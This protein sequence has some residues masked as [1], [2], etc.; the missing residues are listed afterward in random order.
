MREQALQEAKL[1]L[2]Q[3]KFAVLST[4]SVKLAGYPMGS[5]VQ[6]FIDQQGDI[7]VFISE[8]AEHTKNLRANNKLAL[9]VIDLANENASQTARTTCIGEAQILPESQQE[10]YKAQFIHHFPDAQKYCMLADFAI[11][12][13]T[14]K[15]IRYIGGFGKA[16]W[17]EKSHWQSAF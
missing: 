6:F 1:I 14:I 15:R 17:I 4:H 7:C 8:L 13:I 10:K 16:F 2:T 11:W 5:S 12:K 3:A 9:S